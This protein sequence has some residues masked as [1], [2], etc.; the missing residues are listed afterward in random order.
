M[1]KFLAIFVS[2]AMV[3][4]LAACSN[5]DGGSNS[6]DD[7]SS[8]NGGSVGNDG[9][10][11][12][13]GDNSGDNEEL[14]A[15]P[16]EAEEISYT[17]LVYFSFDDTTGLTSVVQVANDGSVPEGITYAIKESDHDILIAEGQGAIGNALYLD[18]KYGV[19]FDMPRIDDDSYTI[20]FWFN[21][22][23]V[24]TYGPVVQMGRNL[25]GAT[26]NPVTWVNF[27]KT[28]WGTSDADIFPVLWNRNSSIGTEVAENGVWPWMYAMDDSEHGKREWCLV[29]VVVDGD[30][31][32]C[33]D[34]GMERIGTHF[35]LNGELMHEAT[36][37]N[38]FYQG[39]APE[40]F[41]GDELEGHIGINYW[42]TIYKGFIDE[43][44]IYDEPL[45]AGQVKSLYEAGNPPA[46]PV[47]PEYNWEGGDVGGGDDVE[48]EPLPDAP[49][50]SSAIDVLGTP[51][52]VLGFWS[53][54][55]D[56]YEL[57]DGATLTA[58]FNL[59]SS[60]REN[61]HTIVTAFTNTAVTTDSLA[62]ADNYDGYAEY[63]VVRSDAFGWGDASYNGTFETSWTDWA[64]WKALTTEAKVEIAM[65]RAGGEVTM[66]FTF[67]GA[68]GTE[69]T[70]TG[71]ITSTMTADSPVY[72]HFTGEGAYIEL[73][74]VE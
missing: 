51:D 49:V 11:D 22:D 31:Y 59:Y 20:S 53:D 57:A 45:T 35:Y 28:T 29:T 42:D 19:D 61:Y 72:V 55:T 47:A 40:I 43:F 17:P 38:M 68:D 63:A 25:A 10:G 6:G 34:D 15:P 66:N 56:G 74:S 50:D 13:S 33:A 60:G 58:K 52:R 24:A 44:Y 14:V 54:T 27:T 4:S 18:G 39:V 70:E 7:D 3:A 1:K 62:S 21:A 65:T 64:A 67:T 5:E 23:R 8:N 12:V 46:E 36:S 73:L 69:M 30:R 71:V 26:A 9:A 37:E 48:P 16:V 32:V 2:L 41:A